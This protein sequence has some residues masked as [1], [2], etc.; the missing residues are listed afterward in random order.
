MT[1]RSHFEELCFLISSNICSPVLKCPCRIC[2]APR[3]ISAG[4]IS[5]G[6]RSAIFFQQSILAS[7]SLSRF[8]ATS[9][10]LRASFISFDSLNGAASWQAFEVDPILWTKKGHSLATLLPAFLTAATYPASSCPCLPLATAVSPLGRVKRRLA[11]LAS[12]QPRDNPV[13][14]TPMALGPGSV[15]R[16]GAS[17]SAHRIPEP[18]LLKRT[19]IPTDLD[20]FPY[21]SAGVRFSSD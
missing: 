21:T 3:S 8:E 9:M 18:C 13:E 10:I 20:P 19:C 5:G 14:G 15:H 7:N 17:S 12:I 1:C 11:L 16:S 2:S 4:S 6:C